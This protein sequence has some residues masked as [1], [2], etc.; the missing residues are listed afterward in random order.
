MFRRIALTLA[1]AAS[2]AAVALAPT[3]ASAHW[4]GHGWHGHGWHGHANFH[5]LGPP[6]FR[7]VTGPG[8]A[9]MVKRWVPTPYGPRLRWVN[10]C[11]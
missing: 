11:F 10:V 8:P 9:C 5:R 4:R 7:V 3:S 2:L 6:A 1:A